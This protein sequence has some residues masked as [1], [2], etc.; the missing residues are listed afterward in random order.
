MWNLDTGADIM[1]PAMEEM[2]KIRFYIQ[3][4]PSDIIHKW[5]IAPQLGRFQNG[6][7]PGDWGGHQV[8]DM[9][10]EMCKNQVLYQLP[11][12][13]T[14]HKWILAPEVGRL[15]NGVEP[16]HWGGHQVSGHETDVSSHVL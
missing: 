15:Q 7:K 10:P 13:D 3:L 14:I 6:V 16:G 4:P 11:P 9:C 12:S 5:T 2:C 1:Y 8:T